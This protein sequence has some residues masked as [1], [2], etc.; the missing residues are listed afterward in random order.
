[1]FLSTTI[2]VLFLGSTNDNPILI[3]F[4]AGAYF[5]IFKKVTETEKYICFFLVLFY[6]EMLK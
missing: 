3:R 2:R 6:S 1:M 5:V 4:P